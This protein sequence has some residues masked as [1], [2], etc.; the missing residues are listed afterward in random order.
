MENLPKNVF[1]EKGFNHQMFTNDLNMDLPLRAW[2]E[3]TVRGVEHTPTL[4]ER[5]TF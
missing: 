1:G 3:K 5:K 4:R 2:I